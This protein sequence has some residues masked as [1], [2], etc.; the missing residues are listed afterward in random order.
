MDFDVMISVIVPIFKVETY[1]REC[2]DSVLGQSYNDY[3]LILVD[4]GS[5]DGC[6]AICDE[7]ATKDSRIK[8]VHKPNGGLVSARKA[9]VI[10][11]TGD[12]AMC[13][14]GDDYLE[15]DCLQKVAEQIEK[16]S[17]D[18][19]CFGHNETCNGKLVSRPIKG[20]ES[21]VY[22]RNEIQ[23]KIFPNLLYS[24]TK[25]S[26]P[27]SVWA[28]CYKMELYREEQLAVADCIKIGED[29]AVSK[30]CVYR[31]ESLV[32][33]KCCLYN[34][35]L[36]PESMTKD[37]KPFNLDNYEWR[38]NH[39][40]NRIDSTSF[41]FQQ[42]LDNYT[43]HGLFNACVTQFYAHENYFKVCRRI[44]KC[45]DRD[46]Y[47]CCIKNA[48]FQSSKNAQLMHFAMKYRLYSLMWLYSKIR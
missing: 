4:D 37:R 3:E 17:P 33:M 16:F 27:A 19:I 1:L 11:A 7:Y 22:N 9:G 40:M 47:R 42:Q 21:E 48:K 38:Y 44:A 31:A 23:R 46:V 34:Y 6:P 35:R 28:K 2:V 24:M 29:Y 5:P 8:V 45:L 39:I 41:G 32:V 36:N 25:P 26:F 18:V 13:L 12:Y 20:Y 43:V 15:A 14:D 10:I 30:P